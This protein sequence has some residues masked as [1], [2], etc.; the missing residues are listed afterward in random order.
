MDREIVLRKKFKNTHFLN[1]PF[2]INKKHLPNLLTDGLSS[3]K[4]INEVKTWH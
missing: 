4:A 2:S 3:W 1:P